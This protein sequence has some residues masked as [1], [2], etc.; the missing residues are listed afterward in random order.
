M[1]ILLLLLFPVTAIFIVFI[2]E[3]CFL[4]YIVVV[5]V[6]I[7]IDM[8]MFE[9]LTIIPKAFAYLSFISFAISAMIRACRLGL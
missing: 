9:E 7:G 8:F 1:C 6:A 2:I 5:V 4:S 3:G